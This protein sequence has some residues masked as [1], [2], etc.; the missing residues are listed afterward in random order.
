MGIFIQLLNIF[1]III[2]RRL[3]LDGHMSRVE[4]TRSAQR[5]LEGKLL[6]KVHVKGRGDYTAT[7]VLIVES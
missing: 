4:E 2:S 6:R 1:G 7:S 3:R 5:I